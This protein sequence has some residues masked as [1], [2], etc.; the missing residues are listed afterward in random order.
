MENSIFRAEDRTL[1][2]Q[3]TASFHLCICICMQRYAFSRC[4]FSTEFKIRLTPE[5]MAQKK[6]AEEKA[7]VIIDVWGTEMIQLIVA[8]GRLKKG[9]S[10]SYFSYRSG[11][12]HPILHI[13]L[14]QLILFFKSSWSKLANTAKIL[15]H[16]AP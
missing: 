16:F 15:S 9:M 5:P 1:K 4:K 11:A 3:Y 2:G 13:V 6:D 7:K 10:S 8:P 12:I 14:I